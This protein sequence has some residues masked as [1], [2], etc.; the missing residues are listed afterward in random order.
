MS[1]ASVT[2][3]WGLAVALVVLVGIAVAVSLPGRF[4]ISR[5]LAAA[6]VRA[7]L[8]LAVV[9]T[10]IVA[11]VRSWWLTVAFVLLMLGVAAVT[12]GRRMTRDRSGSV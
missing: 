3:G 1:G 12:S 2:V 7:V 9:A 4:E 8:Q 6:S 11:L 10:I 5:A